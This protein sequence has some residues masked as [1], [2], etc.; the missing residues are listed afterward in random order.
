MYWLMTMCS[1][2]KKN[3][4]LKKVEY[5]PG[6]EGVSIDT[7]GSGMFGYSTEGTGLYGIT[8]DTLKTYTK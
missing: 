7:L 1:C 4:P 8:I 6:W 5:T 2:S 3:K